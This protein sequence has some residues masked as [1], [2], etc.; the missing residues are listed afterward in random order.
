MSET[1]SQNR[2]LGYAR[3]S[4]LRGAG[5]SKIYREKVTGAST[6]LW[7]DRFDGSL[8]DIFDAAGIGLLASHLWAR[9]RM[10]RDLLCS[11]ASCRS[12]RRPGGGPSGGRRFRK[13][14]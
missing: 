3:V 8:E 7:A 9:T 2:I 1:Q 5:C 11:A 4:T 13:A 6:H 12:E 10:G 14:S